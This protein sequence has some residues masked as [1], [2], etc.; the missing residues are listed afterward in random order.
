MYEMNQIESTYIYGYFFGKVIQ[1]NFYLE[2]YV[3]N[4]KIKIL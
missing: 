2:K 1:K 3:K 4:L